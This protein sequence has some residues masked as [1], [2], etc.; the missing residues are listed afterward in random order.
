M[1]KTHLTI[2][3]SIAMIFLTFLTIAS[4]GQVTKTINSN[5][6]KE[7]S[8]FLDS[9][10]IDKNQ[11]FDPNKI[12]EINVVK[13][14]DTTNQNYGKIYMKSKNPKDYN[15]L[16]LTDIKKTY[17]KSVSVPALFMID[18]KIL[19][20]NISTYKIDSTYILTVEILK[21]TEIESLKNSLPLLT[22]INIKLKTKENIDKANE[23]YIRGTG[24]TLT[25]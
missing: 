24:T 14:K 20:D 1:T 17:A 10:R 11:L 25:Q 2:M 9:I 5:S 3:K 22:I 7:P 12:A 6:K 4:Y 15:F 18:N 8:F 13:D 21:S 23:I 19:K 16:T